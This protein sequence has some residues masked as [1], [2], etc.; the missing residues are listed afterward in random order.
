M[1]GLKRLATSAPMYRTARIPVRPPQ[2]R[3][4]PRTVPLSRLK[5]ATPQ[6]RGDLPSVQRAQLRQLGQQCEREL[7]TNPGDTAQDVILLPPHR[8]VTQCLPQLFADV[9]ELVL[10]PG[11]VGLDP[12]SDGADRA[13]KP[14]LLSH[15]DRYYLKSTCNHRT[16][17][18]GLGV[19]QRA[20]GWTNRVGEVGQCGRVQGVGFR[21][22]PGGCKRR[23]NNGPCRRVMA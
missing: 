20:H 12:G 7:F 15:Q 2:T 13:P 21:Q 5:G 4:F 1:T 10:E 19:L 11:D 16:Q 14:V 3:L 17:D 9:A 22:S 8:T 23:S 18:L 6:Q